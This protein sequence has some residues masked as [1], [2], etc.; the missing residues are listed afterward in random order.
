MKFTSAQHWVLG[1]ALVLGTVVGC[2]PRGNSMSNTTVTAEVPESSGGETAVEKAV[3]G[4]DIRTERDSA[5]ERRLRELAPA[6]PQ[7]QLRHLAETYGWT[8]VNM[9][10]E[11]GPTVADAMSWLGAE[12]AALAREYPDTYKALAKSFN[13]RTTVAFLLAVKPH[14]KELGKY[15]G[16]P[17]MVER[18]EAMPSEAKSLAQHYPAAIPF[19]VMAPEEVSAALRQ[20]PEICLRVF[21]PVDLSVGAH[22][23][24]G[25]IG[26]ADVAEMVVDL[27]GNRLQ[28]WVDAAGLDGLLLA[29]RFPEYFVDDLPM[30]LEVF[31]GILSSNQNDIRQMLDIGKRQDVDW[32]LR[33]VAEQDYLLPRNLSPNLRETQPTAGMWYNLA[34]HDRRTIRFLA[35][36]RQE[37]IRAVNSSWHFYLTC[38]V[39]TPTL[40]IEGFP[41]EA[42][43]RHALDALLKAAETGGDEL[44]ATY[45]SFLMRFSD[46][47]KDQSE[48]GARV[49]RVLA[50]CDW[51][52]VPYLLEVYSSPE[53]NAFINRLKM[54]ED[55]GMDELDAWDMPP[56]AALEAMPGYDA[57]HLV[58]VLAN[59]YT[60]TGQE[61][62]FGAVDGVFTAVDIV[63]L[64]GSAILRKPLLGAGK[65]IIEEG[66]E[67][68][69]KKTAKERLRDWL[70][71]LVRSFGRVV[72]KAPA[73][74]GTMGDDITSN[75]V[76]ASRSAEAYNLA[77]RACKWA[78]TEWTVGFGAIEVLPRS[79]EV[80]VE[81]D[82][83]GWVAEKT[84]EVLKYMQESP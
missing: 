26:I 22:G 58:W 70:D 75:A 20:S 76:R 83:S 64:S 54:L 35:T 8:A 4:V 73:T 51:R 67:L 84:L 62:L 28:K 10:K 36:F 3:P 2:G 77:L 63:T 80:V 46:V 81:A 79:V 38:A 33:A 71:D 14:L 78:A 66:A 68:A 72:R 39:G 61:L 55:R 65:E 57:A 42:A 47:G 5:V 50:Q 17:G 34:Q 11:Y 52:V 13:G 31:L 29:H 69:V 18:I 74:I 37:G 43:R 15:G 41:E 6:L 45:Q 9:V 24:E 56:P 82:K 60:P 30:S 1:T 59:G 44:V 32:A 12:G 48:Y 25:G 27:S 19:L 23:R 21:P 7:D 40:L 53:N 16:L 49:R